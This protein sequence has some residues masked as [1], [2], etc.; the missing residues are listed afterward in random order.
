MQQIIRPRHFFRTRYALPLALLATGGTLLAQDPQ[1]LMGQP[2]L[3]L[4]PVQMQHFEE[5]LVQFSTPL[6]EALGLGPIFNE[7]SCISCHNQPAVGGFS[8]RRVTRFGKAA[9]GATPFDPLAGLGGTLLQDQSLD[10][11]CREVVPTEANHQIQRG[12]PALFGAGLIESIPEVEILAAQAAQPVA[13]QGTPRYVQPIESPAGPMLLG[14][15]GWKGGISTVE[16]FSIDASLNEMGLT[17]P[18]A[19]T[20]NAPNGDLGLL[21]SCDSVSDPED[22]PDAAGFTLTQRFTHFQRYLAAPAQTPRTG[23]AGE[24]LFDQVGCADCHVSSFTTGQVPEAALSGV[25]IR[26]YSDFLLHDMGALGDGIVDGIATET[27]M[28]TRPLWGMAQRT[29]LLHDGRATGANFSGLIDLSVAE[30]GGQADAS[31]LAYQALLGSERAQVSDFLASLGR[32]E[33]DWDTD[34]DLTEFDWFFLEPLMTGPA[35]AVLLTA[36]DPGALCDVD[37]D[38]DFDLVEFGK[39]QRVWTAQ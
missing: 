6:T 37:V 28:M 23:M 15:F 32:A 7:V 8:T 34:N 39:L 5:G 20:E 19:S 25:L 1:P 33:F 35:P 29:A 13:V 18:F 3:G 27:I 24:V 12:T 30:H 4:T 36:D 10:L 17:S 16:S 38:G 26:P 2:M 11:A 14:R 9:V 22:Q 21:A 31:R